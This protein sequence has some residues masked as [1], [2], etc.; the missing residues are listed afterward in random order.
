ML[1]QILYSQRLSLKN[2][3][4]VSRE[5]QNESNIHVCI[6]GFMTPTPVASYF[7][8]KCAT[9]FVF[10]AYPQLHLALCV[11]QLLIDALLHR[12]LLTQLLL[13]ILDNQPSW[14]IIQIKSRAKPFHYW[15]IAPMSVSEI[16]LDWHLPGINALLILSL[17]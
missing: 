16:I 7:I 6:S 10:D 15:N 2:S 14:N 12:S 3:I 1:C 17:Q 5:L 4:S 11:A 9:L 8:D 13:E